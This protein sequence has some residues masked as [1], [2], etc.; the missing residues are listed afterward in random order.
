MKL[1]RCRQGSEVFWAVV[2]VEAGTARPFSGE[3]PDWG[4]AMTVDPAG[5]LP[6]LGPE[7]DLAGVR[8]LAPMT[9]GAAVVGAGA[10]YAKHIAG[11]GLQMPEQP[12]AFHK[13]ARTIVGPE[14][15]ISYPG[16]TEALDYEAELVVVVGTPLAPDRDPTLSILGYT[17]G[18]E[19]S[20]RDLQFGGSVTGMDIFSAKALD[21]TA[22]I[23]PWIV[24]RDEFGDEHP[25]L[26]ITLTIDGEVRQHDRTSSMAWGVGFL[27]AYVNDRTAMESGD[28]FFTGT[29]SGVGHEDGRYLEPGQVVEITIE[30]IGTLR[31]VVGPRD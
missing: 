20:A 5:G 14:D 25:D 23:G 6:E 2:D 13:S 10:T 9:P 12:A 4:P 29:M 17:I 31:N 30:G 21:R 3:V 16:I 19:V 11:M 7:R 26:E 15:E 8:L 18:N 27:L 28:I 1:A 22:P 24:T